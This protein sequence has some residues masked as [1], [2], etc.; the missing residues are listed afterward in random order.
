MVK[1]LLNFLL[2]FLMLS[3]LSFAAAKYNDAKLQN[4]FGKD[5]TKAPFYL[6]FAYSQKFNK[7]WGKTSYKEREAFLGDYEI[8]LAKEQA[9][10]NAEAKAEAQR[11][12]Q[13]LQEQ[14]A[15]DRQD[16]ER[17]KEDEEEDKAQEQEDAQRQKQF[18]QG[19]KDQQRT[20]DQM[21]RQAE[22]Q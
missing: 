5:L 15:E 13:R 19:L 9:R 14:K 2:V 20:L 17:L 7:E 16:A 10:E 21:E 6:R 12:K 1:Y 22:G 4:E 3:S 18:D 8:N 11:E